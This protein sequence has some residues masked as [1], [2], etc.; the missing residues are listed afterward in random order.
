MFGSWS[1]SGAWCLIIGV[2]SLLSAAPLAVAVEGVPLAG[3]HRVVFLGDSI[4]YSGQYVD[5]VEVVL[6]AASLMGGMEFLDLGLPS[7]TVSGL[8]EPGHAGGKFPRPDLHE[9]LDRVLAK[10]RPDVV[11]ACYGMNDG[12]YYPF[13][14]E[15]FRKFQ[16]GMLWLH[17]SVVKS[18]A[19]IIHLTPPTFDPVPIKDRTL[20]AGLEEYRR[21]YEGYNE[22]LD[23]YSAWLVSQR[24]NGWQVIDVHTPMNDYLARRRKQSPDFALTRDGVHADDTGHWLIARQVLQGL[25]L[26]LAESKIDLDRVQELASGRLGAVL[27]K[28]IHEK[29]RLL[30]D[31]WLSD[32]GHKR[33]GM[34]PGLPLG[35]AKVKSAGLLVRINELARQFT[36]QLQ[37]GATNGPASVKPQ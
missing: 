9:R 15:R 37:T 23:R 4:T 22:V 24:T 5:D 7:E 1:F 11:I 3:A 12:I 28:S 34:N 18:G 14:E 8:S 27:L 20:P 31:A 29:N 30:S 13:G 33:P 21:P 10:A 2:C 32:I 25:N 36:M 35:D 16:D 19:R 26:P 17:G 6:R